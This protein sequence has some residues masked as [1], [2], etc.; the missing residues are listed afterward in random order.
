MVVIR[1]Q[2]GAISTT[3][4]TGADAQR[5]VGV[6][7]AIWLRMS[8]SRFPPK[9]SSDESSVRAG[10]LFVNDGGGPALPGRHRPRTDQPQARAS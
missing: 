5:I 2:N 4:I 3:Q 9:E 8:H 10:F 1:E 7:G 6:D